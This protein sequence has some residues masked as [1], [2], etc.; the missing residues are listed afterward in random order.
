MYVQHTDST[1]VAQSDQNVSP[2]W[3]L[4]VAQLT[5]DRADDRGGDLIMMK[6]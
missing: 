4:V 5:V 1:R 2:T 3:H 6:D